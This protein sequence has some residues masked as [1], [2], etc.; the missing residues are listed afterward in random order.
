MDF[1]VP[2][3]RLGWVYFAL[4]L[5]NFSAMFHAVTP[6]ALFAGDMTPLAR[7]LKMTWSAG[8]LALL[9]LGFAACLLQGMASGLVHPARGW[10]RIATSAACAAFFL[11]QHAQAEEEGF[12][13]Q[14]AVATIE[15]QEARERE[16]PSGLIASVAASALAAITVLI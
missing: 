5:A 8:F 16:A 7:L 3:T 9:E 2:S 14:P 6:Q 15:W 13:L 4:M 12:P 11:W 1:V 10:F